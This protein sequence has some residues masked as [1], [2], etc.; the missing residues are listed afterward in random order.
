MLEYFCI[1]PQ[2]W[3]AFSMH[4]VPWFLFLF[5][6]FHHDYSRFFI[7]TLLSLSH[8]IFPPLIHPLIHP[9][10]LSGRALVSSSR[11]RRR[12]SPRF[13]RVSPRCS[14]RSASAPSSPRSDACV[15]WPRAR[16]AARAHTSA[17][18]RGAA[19][20][21]CGTCPAGAWCRPSK[22][23]RTGAVEG[24]DGLRQEGG[25]EQDTAARPAAHVIVPLI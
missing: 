25:G 24:V 8:L 6:S 20:S 12:P 15:R 13:N 1:A 5:A 19:C 23:T 3:R 17:P 9:Y 22:V 11:A 2:T 16:S 10:P 18:C 14:P 4:A 7:D 21:S